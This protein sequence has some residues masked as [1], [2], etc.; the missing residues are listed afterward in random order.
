MKKIL[1]IILC[2][3]IYSTSFWWWWWKVIEIETKVPI[4]VW[5]KAWEYINDISYRKSS[6]V[7]IDQNLDEYVVIPSKWMVIP[8]Y[9]IN[10]GSKDYKNLVNFEY[11]NINK[12]LKYWSLIYPDN[13]NSTYWEK[14]NITIMWHSSYLKSDNWRYKTHFQVII[15]LE[16]WKEIWIYKKINDKFK[17]FR[18]IV[19]KSYDT[20]PYDIDIINSTDKSELTL[21]TCTPIW[22][23]G[24]RWIIKAEFIKEI[25]YNIPTSLKNKIEKKLIKKIRQ[26]DDPQKKQI[27]INKIIYKLNKINS[28]NQ[29]TINIINYIKDELKK[30][31]R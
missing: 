1:L 22:W 26:I 2:L 16:E 9:R 31:S 19:K 8:I 13:I 28:N 24:W 30:E 12:Y 4:Y 23:D 3:S 15:W 7:S 29:S 11:V 5:E 10:Q 6:V 20:E 18:Y 14:W 27:T 25:D 21:F 17:R